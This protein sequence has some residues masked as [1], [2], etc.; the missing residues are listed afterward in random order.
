MALKDFASHLRLKTMSD[1]CGE[2]IISGR[3]GQIFSY[4]RSRMGVMFLPNPAPAIRQWNIHRKALE[5]VGCVILQDCEGEGT[6]LFDPENAE[7]VMLALRVAGVRTKRKLSAT[8]LAALLASSG[9]TRFGSD[10]LAA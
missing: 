8:H 10:D 3:T 1:E 4:D 7:Q 9:Q 2:L 5:R 6:A